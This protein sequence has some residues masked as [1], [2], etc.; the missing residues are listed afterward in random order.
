MK[1]KLQEDRKEA[2]QQQKLRSIKP[3]SVFMIR[4]KSEQMQTRPKE[5]IVIRMK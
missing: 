5:R 2:G 4:K 3:P 1:L